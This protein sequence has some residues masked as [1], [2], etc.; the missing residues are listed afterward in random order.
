LPFDSSEGPA[1]GHV[2]RCRPTGAATRGPAAE[3]PCAREA[4]GRWG[5]LRERWKSRDAE[6]SSG[7]RCVLRQRRRHGS[8]QPAANRHV[9][10]VRTRPQWLISEIRCVGAVQRSMGEDQVRRQPPGSRRPRR[11]PVAVERVGQRRRREP[12]GEREARDGVDDKGP[13]ARAALPL[14]WTSSAP[15]SCC[16]ALTR[17]GPPL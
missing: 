6:D 14:A 15:R 1:P 5:A 3:C 9:R 17:S 11:A 16:L 12:Q 13:L 2:K 7:L 4:H 8:L 10:A